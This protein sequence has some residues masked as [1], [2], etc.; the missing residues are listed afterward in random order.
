MTLPVLSS[1]WAEM[2]PNQPSRPP[3]SCMVSAPK[4]DISSMLASYRSGM[5]IMPMGSVLD[6]GTAGKAG[7]GYAPVWLTRAASLL[8]PPAAP[9]HTT[10]S[11]ADTAMR[12]TVRATDSHAKKRFVPFW[13]C[14]PLLLVRGPVVWMSLTAISSSCEALLDS[15]ILLMTAKAKERANKG[16]ECTHFDTLTQAHAHQLDSASRSRPPPRTRT[17]TRTHEMEGR[18]GYGRM[19]GRK[20]LATDSHRLMMR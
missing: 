13:R 12:A 16:N 9:R 1:C 6:E 15:I 8:L 18:V 3:N 2:T 17:R 5:D 4:D 19:Y 14:L 7:G 10:V 20:R 11:A